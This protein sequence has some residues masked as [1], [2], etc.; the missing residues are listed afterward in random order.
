MSYTAFLKQQCYIDGAWID[1][2]S[3]K[4]LTVTDPGT[5]QSLG[6]V[7]SMAEA[8]TARAIAAADKAL[9]GWR[10]RTA[11]ELVT[12]PVE[13]RRAQPASSSP[14]ALSS[15]KLRGRAGWMVETACLY[16][17]WAMPSRVSNMQNRSKPAI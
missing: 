15:A 9:P 2:D 7:P 14:P 17:S 12:V 13:S 8:E 6:T 3:G 10:A 5:G 16:T 11:G 4:T 1:A